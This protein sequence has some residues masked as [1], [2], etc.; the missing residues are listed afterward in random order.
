MVAINAMLARAA[1]FRSKGSFARVE[2]RGRADTA[3]SH[4]VVAMSNE[5]LPNS[6]RTF[7]QERIEHYED[8][9]LL[10]FLRA[11]AGAWWNSSAIAKHLAVASE[12]IEGSLERLLRSALID[13]AEG[14]ASR[15]Y[16]YS[17]RD[18]ATAPIVDKLADACAE[19]PLAVIKAMT[20]NAL[21]RLRARSV[22]T[23]ERVL[24]S[25][26]RLRNATADGK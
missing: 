23:F 24:K 20:G 13:S 26:D 25:R 18:T 16:R 5:E 15:V 6:L 9:Q 2:S 17:Q 10:L 8:L 3:Y 21:E 1:A 12:T 7:L 11:K 22:G 4:L 14:D 19:H